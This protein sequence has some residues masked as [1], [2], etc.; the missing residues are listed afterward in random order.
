MS[1]NGILKERFFGFLHIYLHTE[2]S[3]EN[4]ILKNLETLGLD[5]CREQIYDNVANISG[6]KTALKI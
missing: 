1:E 4:E 3:L 2:E 6:S 5:N